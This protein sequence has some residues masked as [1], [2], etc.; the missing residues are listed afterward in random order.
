MRTVTLNGQKVGE[1]QPLVAL[2]ANALLFIVKAGGEE[3][4]YDAALIL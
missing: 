1:G 4:D 3:L 2:S